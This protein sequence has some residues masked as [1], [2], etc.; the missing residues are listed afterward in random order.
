MWYII[1][2]GKQRMDHMKNYSGEKFYGGGGSNEQETN[3]Y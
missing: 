1:Y 2:E 3:T